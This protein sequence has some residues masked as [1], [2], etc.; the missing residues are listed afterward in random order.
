MFANA[1]RQVGSTANQFRWVGPAAVGIGGCIPAYFVYDHY[2]T[3]RQAKTYEKLVRDRCYLDIGIG[4][5][6]A[7]R[8][9]VGLYSDTVPLTC[10]N[11]V[12]LCKGYRIKERIIGYQNTNIHLIKSGCAIAGGDVLDGTGRTRGLSIY[13]EAFPDENFEISFL[14][15]GDLAMCNWGKNTNSS[16]WMITLSQQRAFTNHH[17][18]FGTVIKGMRVVREI[19]ELGTRV[20]RPAVPIRIVQCGVLEDGKEPPPPPSVELEDDTA[21]LMTEDEFRSISVSALDFA[22]P[23]LARAHRLL[24]SSLFLMMSKGSVYK[25]PVLL[26]LAAAAWLACSV[27]KTLDFVGVSPSTRE[28]ALSARRISVTG[29]HKEVIRGSDEWKDS[30]MNKWWWQK[31]GYMTEFGYKENPNWNPYDYK[32]A[33][34]EMRFAYAEKILMN[35]LRERG[36]TDEEI[37]QKASVF[38]FV[39]GEKQPKL[40]KKMQFLLQIKYLHEGREGE[41]IDLAEEIEKSPPSFSYSGEPDADVYLSLDWPGIMR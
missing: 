25:R 5:R 41:L 7:G 3:Q 16:I 36:M 2:D 40:T 37:R 23:L 24:F 6:Y 9:I 22:L 38:E 19:G 29:S 39:E 26:A 17:V 1:A 33:E 21:P 28:P 11:F 27:Q 20:G 14:R 30:M 35:E 15:D 8:I 31:E 4:N 34:R 12:Q 10:E 18:C 32:L 13:G